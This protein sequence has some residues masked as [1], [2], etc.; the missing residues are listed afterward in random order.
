MACQVSW[1]RNLTVSQEAVI[2]WQLWYKFVNIPSKA[3]NSN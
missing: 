2:A 1:T 3:E